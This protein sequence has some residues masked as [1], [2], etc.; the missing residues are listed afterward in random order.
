[1]ECDSCRFKFP[2]LI[3]IGD[4]DAITSGLSSLT[5]KT[6]LSVYA[7]FVENLRAVLMNGSWVLPRIEQVI[8]PTV[9]PGESLQDFL[10]RKAYVS[11]TYTCVRCGGSARFLKEEAIDSFS[12]KYA[13]FVDHGI[14]MK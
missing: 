11:V 12:E 1:M 7:V 5:N 13:V 4:S 14:T 10:R 8:H 3:F 6:S 2:V 9:A